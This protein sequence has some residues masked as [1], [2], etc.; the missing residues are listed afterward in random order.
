[1]L[2]QQL[3]YALIDSISIIIMH[4]VEKVKNK[5][6]HI[7][8]HRKSKTWGMKSKCL[9]SKEGPLRDITGI[10]S[11]Q[12]EVSKVCHH[13]LILFKETPV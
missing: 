4:L 7:P 6:F 1:M 9:Q 11:I 3:Y 10:M 5:T 2:L 13:C 12:L 8:F